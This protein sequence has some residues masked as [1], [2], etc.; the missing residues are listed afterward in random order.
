[1]TPND[2][3]IFGQVMFVSFL[4]FCSPLQKGLE[5]L[6]RVDHLLTLGIK[7]TKFEFMILAPTFCIHVIDLLSLE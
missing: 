6:S 1:M 7:L 5:P 4:I 3:I 2:L